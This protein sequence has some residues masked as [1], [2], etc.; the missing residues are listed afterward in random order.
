MKTFF[1]FTTLLLSIHCFC[2]ADR[3]VS[4]YVAFNV[5]STM[6]DR[7]LANNAVGFGAGL[8]LYIRTKTWLRAALDVNGEVFGGTKQLYVADGNK[9]IYSKD[10]VV[11][12]FAG[13]YTQPSKRV[14][15][16]FT[17]GPAFF[18]NSTYLGIKPGVGYY[19]VKGRQL[20]VKIC[21]TNIFQ[22]D[23]ISN[24]SFGYFNFSLA[25]KLF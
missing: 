23:D 3:P 18:N 24:K 16:T 5:N 8:Q 6:Y 9:P 12:V 19:L 22:H 2:Q 20:A 15:A 14:F 11:T 25:V 1:C 17:L 7:T 10:E 13:I 4:A 21:F